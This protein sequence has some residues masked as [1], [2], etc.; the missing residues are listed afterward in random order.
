MKKLQSA[1]VRALCREIGERI[2]E[3]MRASRPQ[4]EP[5]ASIEAQMGRLRELDEESPTIVPA[6]RSGRSEKASKKRGL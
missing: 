3:R 6:I 1:H 5:P 2:G 4:S